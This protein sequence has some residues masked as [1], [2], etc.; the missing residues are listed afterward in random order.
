MRRKQ[1]ACVA[2]CRYRLY[3]TMLPCCLNVYTAFKACKVRDAGCWYYDL[4]TCCD[5]RAAILLPAP[6][7]SFTSHCIAIQ[8]GQVTNL[9]QKRVD[10]PDDFA[11]LSQL[12]YYWQAI[13]C[14]Q[15]ALKAREM[16]T[17]WVV[18]GS[19]EDDKQVQKE[20][21]IIILDF[22]CQRYHYIYNNI[23]ITYHFISNITYVLYIYI[24]CDVRWLLYLPFL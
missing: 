2:R 9:V 16:W 5:G 13:V 4:I 20:Q 7:L 24:Y 3:S 15:S 22:R 12:R 18:N 14:S 11:W 6:A 8:F 21:H 17:D 10:S 1:V 19:A 23:I